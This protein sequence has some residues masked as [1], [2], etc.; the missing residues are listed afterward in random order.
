MTL[1]QISSPILSYPT[2]GAANE[3][4]LFLTLGLFWTKV[5]K[6]QATLQGLSIAQAEEIFQDYY[7][8]IE[9]VNSQSA[10]EISIFHKV[11]WMPLMIKKSQLNS[12]VLVFGEDEV[13]FGDTVGSESYIFGAAKPEDAKVYVAPLPDNLTE[14]SIIT[15]RVISPSFVLVNNM[16]V[17]IHNKKLYFYGNP[18]ELSNISTFKLL[19]AKGNIE[20][21]HN[22]LT[23]QPIP[24]EV[25]V[26][27]VYNGKIDTNALKYN[28]GYLFGA[29]LPS[30]QGSKEILAATVQLFSEGPSI[31]QLKTICCA[32]LGIKP[33]LEE[34]ETVENIIVTDD[35]TTIV[36]NK[37]VY[38]YS[39]YY[40]LNTNVT[41][42]AKLHAGDVP[43]DAVEFFDD[44]A[45]RSW[46]LNKLAPK[47]SGHEIGAK[48]PK[49]TFPSSMFVG[50]YQFGLTFNNSMEI[51]T[52]ANNVITFPVEGT[53]HDVELFHEHINANSTVKAQVASAVGGLTNNNFMLINP[54]DF[55][56]SSFLRCNSALMK[57]N[58]QTQAEIS[59]F[60]E[61]F[62]IIKNCLPAHVY[63]I[64]FFDLPITVEVM[65]INHS[66]GPTG[67]IHDTFLAYGLYTGYTGYTGYPGITMPSLQL[68]CPGPQASS[69]VSLNSWAVT[70]SADDNLLCTD[71]LLVRPIPAG[72]T[73][74]D[75]NFLEI[76]NY[77]DYTGYTGYT[78]FTGYTGY[79][80]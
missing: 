30:S 31:L 74:E 40:T 2:T 70:G 50:D 27:W 34:Q 6:D 78:G 18:F 60:T 51:I 42:G 37:N 58:F 35:K 69:I 32:L 73:T 47:I 28:I 76:M 7:N 59:L 17:K 1:S 55:I 9:A 43:V 53:V 64:F 48:S 75:Y 71:R 68:H 79:I 56:F 11:K 65:T 10:K 49:M 5:F 4:V 57:I 13:K 72:A 20:Y 39:S 22:P 25:M 36:T 8:L 62:H 12:D 23:G 24:D 52:M 29:N 54:L 45:F 15:N 16:D 14:V 26:L 67:Y 44:V 61:Y 41:T 33:I 77:T 63:F 3:N 66:N 80:L 21:Y 38:H 46:W 19:D